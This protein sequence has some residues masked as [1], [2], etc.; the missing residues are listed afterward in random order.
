MQQF[1]GLIFD[2][3][4]TLVDSMPPHYK[5]WIDVLNRHGLVMSEDRYYAM[6]GWPTVTVAETLIKETGKDLDP[7]QIRDEKESAFEQFIHHVQPIE[8]IVQIVKEWY[9]QIPMA[10][11]TGG[12]RRICEKTLELCDL[13][14]YFEVIVTADDV[15]RPKPAPDVYLRAAE[16]LGVDPTKCRAYEDADPGVVSAKAAGMDVI[17]VRE[18]HSPRRVTQP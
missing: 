14:Q 6:G 9:G 8:P 18:F 11:A 12:I 7:A 10:V 5:A 16:L 13:R 17:D 1:E 3:D 15:A 2:C 4:G